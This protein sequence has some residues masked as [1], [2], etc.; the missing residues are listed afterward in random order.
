M[1]L[2]YGK[3]EGNRFSGGSK[4]RA[5]GPRCS[6]LS[7]MRHASMTNKRAPLCRVRLQLTCAASCAVLNLASEAEHFSLK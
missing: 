6:Q 7:V 5:L 1:K 2:L 4:L 3:L